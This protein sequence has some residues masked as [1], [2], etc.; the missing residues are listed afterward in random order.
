MPTDISYFYDNPV[1]LMELDLSPVARKLSE[2]PAHRFAD[3]MAAVNGG[4]ISRE[5]LLD[6]RFLRRA[7]GA[8][9]NLFGADSEE[10][11][12]S[13][14]S[15][16]MKEEA[17]PA[18]I[19]GVTTLLQGKLEYR[20][21]TVNQKLDGVQLRLRLVMRR[22]E[23]DESLTS[24]LVV[25]TDV[26]RD[27]TLIDQVRMLSM[28]P[29][30]NPN[31][32]MMMACENEI[33]YA[34]PAARRWMIGHNL[35]HLDDLHELLPASFYENHCA[36]CDRRTGRSETYERHGRLY[37]LKINPS[38]GENRCVLYAADVTETVLRRQ[39]R[40]LFSKAIEASGN[41][42][43]IT[44]DTGAIEYINPAFTRLYGY[45]LEEARGQNPRIINPGVH[46]YWDM[47]VSEEGYRALFD[48]MWSTVTATGAWE[49]EVLNRTQ[50]GE[51]R[52]IHL[53][54]NRIAGG[55]PHHDKYLA[56]GT[57]MDVVHRTELDA[58]LE[59]LSTIT[60]VAELRDNETGYHMRRVG[61][62]SRLLAEQ[63]GHPLRFCSDIE[64]FA[65]LHD[66]GKVGIADSI[67]L[68]PRRLTEE[69][70]ATIK[71]HTTLGYSILAGKPSLE[72]AAEIA[73][74]HHERYDGKGYPEG[75]VG[76]TIATAAR[77]VTVCDVYDALRSA[78]PYK[79]PWPHEKAR[80]EILSNRGTQ[81]C[82]EVA[83]AFD[84]LHTEFQH[85]AERFRERL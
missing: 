10:E 25:A 11:M 64:R 15:D 46:A 7:N 58:R 59:I 36:V 53:I 8:M 61:M 60:R 12:A 26:T 1:A 81:F 13:R 66:I 70:F 24:V 63:M 38:L 80:D 23:D 21:D 31:Y 48:E 2:L 33:T 54:L 52:W 67:L 74:D 85:I 19:A 4:Q 75:K 42:I 50:D 84:V 73:R 9:V 47:G 40:D 6:T 77:I 78:R 43:V 45:E 69:E 30:T 62:Y 72:M 83:V 82:P 34:N 22:A 79:E 76:D 18:M 3:V 57:D 14:F 20:I 29:E 16:I 68:A 56:V 27:T 28:I 35:E 41:A 39:E 51:C 5:T 32:V 49:G 37:D 55:G 65:P 44:D 17:L 71:Q